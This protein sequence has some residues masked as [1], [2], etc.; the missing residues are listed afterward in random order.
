M[1]Y[2]YFSLHNIESRRLDRI[3]TENYY[4]R[5][6]M[7]H[8]NRRLASLYENNTYGS[9][10]VSVEKDILEEDITEEL[11]YV[12][13]LKDPIDIFKLRESYLKFRKH[14]CTSEINIIKTHLSL[15][16]DLD[17]VLEICVEEV[18]FVKSY[19]KYPYTFIDLFKLWNVV[20]HKPYYLSLYTWTKDIILD[21]II[22]EMKNGNNVYKDK[23]VRSVIRQINDRITDDYDNKQLS[24]IGWM[25]AKYFFKS[26]LCCRFD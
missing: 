12:H 16:Y 18:E 1:P 9:T 17:T 22:Y 20:Y 5:T 26:I 13:N 3:Q 14:R 10:Y 2:D 11:E 15:R 4:D 6:R 25:Q 19:L 23:K 24:E 8:N 21:K 7:Q